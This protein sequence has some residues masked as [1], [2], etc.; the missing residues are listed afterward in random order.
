MSQ[1]Q[2]FFLAAEKGQRFCIFTPSLLQSSKGALLY[3]H[4]FAEELNKSRRMVAQ[5]ITALASAGFD[6]LQIDMLGCGDSSGDFEDATWADWVADGKLG[7]EWLRANSDAPLW[8]WGL[9]CGGLLATDLARYYG[10]EISLLLWQ[11]IFS[12]ANVV[13]DFLRLALA[14]EFIS[15]GGKA[16]TAEMRAQLKEGHTVEVAGYALSAAM[17]EQIASVTLAGDTSKSR[18][19]KRVGWL[20]IGSDFQT[21]P[22][23]AVAAVLD[24]IQAGGGTV[25]YRCLRGAAF[26]Q[27]SEIE[28]V[29]ALINETESVLTRFGHA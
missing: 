4:P 27:T 1:R 29:P 11:P 26:W 19:P 17:A 9:R 24:Q 16:K 12:G 22:S 18:W 6:V 10:S 25:I 13:R 14:G 15:G 8:L 3:L 21:S 5:Q 2:A 23:P 20:D 28:T 7:V